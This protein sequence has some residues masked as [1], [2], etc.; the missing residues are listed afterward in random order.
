[1]G[2]SDFSTAI[3]PSALT[4]D[5]FFAQR[6]EVADECG[7]RPLAGP[8]VSTERA[9]DFG[10]STLPFAN[11]QGREPE[12]YLETAP[13]LENLPAWEDG[14]VLTLG[15]TSF[16]MDYYSMP[17]AAERLAEVLGS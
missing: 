5:G 8:E 15:A 14:R 9:S 2:P 1:M 7:V 17:V 16:R 3:A 10:D 6:A 11:T 4:D 12:D 13:V